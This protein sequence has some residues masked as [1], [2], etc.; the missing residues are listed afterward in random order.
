[1]HAAARNGHIEMVE[2]LIGAGADLDATPDGKTTP[3]HQASQRGK[4]HTIELLIQSGADVLE[5]DGHP[6]ALH[7][8]ASE[9]YADAV[10]ILLANGAY[11]EHKD[12]FALKPLDRAIMGGHISITE[13]LLDAGADINSKIL[14]HTPLLLARKWKRK[15]IIELLI[16]RGAIE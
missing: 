14:S 1:M 6:S 12:S 9:G 4:T 8:A 5:K 7:F 11:I 2:F 3:L 16:Q 15:V 10:K 13:L